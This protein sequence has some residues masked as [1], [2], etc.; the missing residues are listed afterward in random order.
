MLAGNKTIFTLGFFLLAL[1]VIGHAQQWGI[2]S[3]SK[4]EKSLYFPKTIPVLH[5]THKLV[6]PKFIIFLPERMGIGEK[7]RG[8]F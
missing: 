1:T 6:H 7:N 8:P 4:K 3:I 5:F 2:D